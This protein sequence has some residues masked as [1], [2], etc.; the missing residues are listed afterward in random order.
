MKYFFDTYTLLEIALQNKNFEKYVDADAITLRTNL[1]EL[2]FLLLKKFNQQTADFFLR[3][4]QSCAVDFPPDIIAPA[5]LFRHT[6]KKHFSYIDCL[7]YAYALLNN[8]IFVTGD[9]AFQKMKNVE[10]VR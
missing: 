5:M 4:F 10:I 7:G 8:C 6:Q 1:A 2:Y 9:R 3:Q